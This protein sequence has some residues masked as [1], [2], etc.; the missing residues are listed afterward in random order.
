V[1]GKLVDKTIGF[2][3]SEEDELTGVDETT[4]AE[5]GYDLGGI[6]SGGGFSS[7]TA[8]SAPASVKAEA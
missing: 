5:S 6:R 2:R 7:A 4:H 1:L 8:T 3:I